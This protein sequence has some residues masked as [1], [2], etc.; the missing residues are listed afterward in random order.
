[1]MQLQKIREVSFTPRNLF[2]STTAHSGCGCV[3]GC[4][5]MENV[6]TLIPKERVR[7][8]AEPIATIYRNLGPASA[9]QVVTRA[10]T[11]LAVTMAGLQRSCPTPAPSSSV[12]H[13]RRP[14]V[15]CCAVI[16]TR[17]VRMRF[18]IIIA[19][20]GDR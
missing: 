3:E 13:G 5:F 6:F 1:M 17:S 15:G 19:P 16:R 11:E 7:Q 8:D 18:G 20:A 2:F 10:L 12:A 4:V 14:M 9:E